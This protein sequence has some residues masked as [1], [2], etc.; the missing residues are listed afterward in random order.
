MSLQ[1]PL[2]SEWLI[3]H[4]AAILALLLKVSESTLKITGQNM[5]IPVG[6][7]VSWKPQCSEMFS[8]YGGIEERREGLG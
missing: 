4:T 7:Y 2:L 6:R 8:W 5:R 3:T 1:F